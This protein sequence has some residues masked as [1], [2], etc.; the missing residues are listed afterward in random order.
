MLRIQLTLEALQRL[1]RGKKGRIEQQTAQV[2]PRLQQMI[3][4]G[5]TLNAC[6]R[7]GRDRTKVGTQTR[8]PQTG[9]DVSIIFATQKTHNTMTP[10]RRTMM[11][12]TGFPLAD[13]GPVDAKKTT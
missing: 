5:E 9:L 12:Q 11:N 3:A 1:P 7:L 8:V 13:R 6:Q 2:R 4:A 10:M